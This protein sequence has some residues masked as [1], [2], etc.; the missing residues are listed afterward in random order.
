VTVTV[1]VTVSCGPPLRIPIVTSLTS[2]ESQYTP[3]SE[4]CAAKYYRRLEL[5][6]LMKGIFRFVFVN[7][8]FR[9]SFTPE[10]TVTLGMIIQAGPLYTATRSPVAKKGLER[11]R[12]TAATVLTLIM[13][14]DLSYFDNVF[15]FITEKLRGTVFD[16]IFLTFFFPNKDKAPQRPSL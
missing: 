3:E 5:R 2:H 9:L 4:Q 14:F 15:R 10:V 11:H 16:L 12:V 1:T 6:D 7:R 8:R 13:F